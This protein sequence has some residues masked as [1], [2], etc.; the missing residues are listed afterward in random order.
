MARQNR[1]QMFMLH[2]KTLNDCERERRMSKAGVG[3]T[4]F[5]NTKEEAK[6]AAED[7][8]RKLKAVDDTEWIACYAEPYWGG[9]P[10]PKDCM[11]R[12]ISTSDVDVTNEP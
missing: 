11:P 5:H 2:P 3:Y 6:A 1:W 9:V 4:S 12:Y 7:T 8:L 10:A